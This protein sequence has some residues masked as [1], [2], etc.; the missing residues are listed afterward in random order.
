M[1]LRMLSGAYAGTVRN[2]AQAAAR[3]MLAD[4]RAELEYPIQIQ[5]QLPA[6]EPVAAEAVVAASPSLGK[7]ASH[8]T[9]ERRK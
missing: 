9:R 6:S 7:Q 4:G 3:A 1:Y 8:G 5:V 2:V